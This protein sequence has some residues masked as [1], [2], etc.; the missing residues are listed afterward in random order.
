MTDYSI[1][2]YFHNFKD[3]LLTNVFK[4]Q[5]FE[6]FR[7][8][9]S[10]LDTDLW[11]FPFVESKT[12]PVLKYKTCTQMNQKIKVITMVIQKL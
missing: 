3:I 4:E 6:V 12:T 11:M 8:I 9:Q 5:D 7:I 1:E 2:G 10:V